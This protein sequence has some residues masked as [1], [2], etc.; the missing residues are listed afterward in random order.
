MFLLED[1]DASFLSLEM[2]TDGK[3]VNAMFSI[4]QSGAWCEPRSAVLDLQMV[5]EEGLQFPI[6]ASRRRF[7][8]GRKVY[9]EV[10]RHVV[11]LD[12]ATSSFFTLKLPDGV[13]HYKFSR[14]QHSGLYL[15]D[16]TEFQLRV[17]YGDGLGQWVLEDTICV[18]EACGH[19]NVQSWKPDDGCA[20]VLVV[21]AGDN[22]EFVFLKL[23]ASE[24]ICCMQLGNRV[25][26]KME[27]TLPD[28]TQDDA[29]PISMIWPPV[30]PA[31]DKPS[32]EH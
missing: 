5:A 20:P 29:V 3:K 23:V 22:A 30:F 17:W 9:M 6:V 13:G 26:D 31:F 8:V 2:A 7:A 12:L 32:Q 24:I 15:I 1:H 11:G 18:R 16:A 10:A 21:A 4:L 25:V 14:A 19:L 27:W 28:F